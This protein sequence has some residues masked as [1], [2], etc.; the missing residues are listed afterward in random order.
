MVD[1]DSGV[2]WSMVDR[3]VMMVAVQSEVD[4]SMVYS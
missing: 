1:V 3:K 2:D 4:W